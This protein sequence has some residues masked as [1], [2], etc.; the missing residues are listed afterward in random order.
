MNVLLPLILSYVSVQQ[1]YCF[2]IF[3]KLH[4]IPELIDFHMS[5]FTWLTRLAEFLKQDHETMNN[6]CNKGCLP[7]FSSH[8]PVQQK[9][10]LKYLSCTFWFLMQILEGSI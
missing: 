2:D 8:I 1:K 10:A 4:L 6:K 7:L 5:L 3:R 9:F